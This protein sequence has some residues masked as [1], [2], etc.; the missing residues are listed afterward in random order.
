MDRAEQLTLLSGFAAD[1]WGL[2]TAAQAKGAGLNGVQLLRLTEVGLLEGVGRGV[3]LVTAVGQPEHLEIKVA[4]LRLQPALPAWRRSADDPD[5]GVVS[6]ASACQLH[7]L[8]D[9]PTPEVEIS[10]PRRRVTTEP[11]VRLRTAL[12]DPSDVTWVDGLPVTTAR[13]T[14]LD[15]LAAKTDG[16]HVGGVIAE[17]ERRGLISIDDLATETGRYSRRYGLPRNSDG[18]A[19]VE[20][21]VA[22]AGESLRSEQLA[23]ANQAGFNQA[24]QMLSTSQLQTG[25]SPL[26]EEIL[27]RTGAQ[28]S[29]HKLLQDAVPSGFSAKL[30]SAIAA[31][32]GDALRLPPVISPEIQKALREATQPAAIR[33]AIA[34]LTLLQ[35]LPRATGS[36]EPPPAAGPPEQE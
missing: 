33:E 22:Q 14:I 18:H 7:N 5:S 29:L 4:W 3:Y 34:A 8:G 13:R 28:A 25:R 35:Q 27:G 10:V 11:S 9:I 16:G 32:Q 19:L 6:H 17:A 23:R 1:Q 36:A 12:I 15:L 31:A 21:L 30:R 20:H 26:L 24:I 2:V